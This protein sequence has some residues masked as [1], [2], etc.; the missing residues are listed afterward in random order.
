MMGKIKDERL[1]ELNIGNLGCAYL[2]TNRTKEAG[3]YYIQALEISRKIKNNIDEC[4]WLG[5][6]AVTE[7][8]LGNN[9]KAVN[10]M[11]KAYRIAIKTNN[12]L[13]VGRWRGKLANMK[14][15]LNMLS[16]EDTILELEGA[17]Q[18]TRREDVL[19][20]RFESY[21]LHDLSFYYSKLKNFE[22]AMEYLN[23][24]VN[25]VGL[26]GDL[27]TKAE[28]LIELFNVQSKFHEP[29]DVIVSIEEAFNLKLRSGR[30][31]EAYKLGK[32]LANFYLSHGITGK[33]LEK[34]KQILEFSIEVGNHSEELFYWWQIGLSHYLN[35]EFEEAIIAY[36]MHIERAKE[37]GLPLKEYNYNIFNLGDT[38]LQLLD[39]DKAVE[40]LNLALEHGDAF[41]H[42]MAN[43]ELALIS[44]KMNRHEEGEQRFRQCFEAYIKLDESE[45]VTNQIRSILSVILILRKKEKEALKKLQEMFNDSDLTVYELKMALH[46]TGITKKVL[47]DQKG[48]DVLEEQINDKLKSMSKETKA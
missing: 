13:H 35:H 8:I 24:A 11:E 46:D 41:I 6:L 32:H 3:E 39:F 15:G 5:N 36:S 7:H 38:Y 1:N 23:G 45:D 30:Q 19:D 22:R 43:F 18:T 47:P 26:M 31:E 48:L 17:L 33:A 14:R 42:F 2:E 4:R 37:L 12:Y 9:E 29:L 44:L 20:R 40:Y 21:W 28:Y 25:V 16:I 34:Y 27:K 10:M